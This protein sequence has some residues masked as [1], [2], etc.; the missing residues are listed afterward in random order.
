MDGDLSNVNPGILTLSKDPEIWREQRRKAMREKI[1]GAGGG[2][3]SNLSTTKSSEYIAPTSSDVAANEAY[4]LKQ[5]LS[6]KRTRE[7]GGNMIPSCSSNNVE[8]P[9]SD[10]AKAPSR[11]LKE[12]LLEK[13]D[14]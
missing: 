9:S 7:E 14:S 8:A 3:E 11:S 2:E 10:L 5:I 4:I 12:R 1:F 6:H 13:Y